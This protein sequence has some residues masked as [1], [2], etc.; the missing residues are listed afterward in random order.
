MA[1]GVSWQ[2][3]PILPLLCGP[4]CSL[5]ESRILVLRVHLLWQGASLGSREHLTRASASHCGWGW[6]K[7][8]AFIKEELLNSL[9][10]RP[11]L[12]LEWV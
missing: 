12:H 9:L 11:E 10:T 4:H 1:Q 2:P 7:R 8:E 5:P 6:G 3:L